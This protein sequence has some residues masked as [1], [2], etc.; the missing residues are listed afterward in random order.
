MKRQGSA[1][2]IG[3]LK[4][5]K[6]NV[7]TESGTLDNTPY[8]F[9]SR[10]EGAVETNPEE[11]IGAAHAGC[12]SMAFAAQLEKEGFK[13]DSIDTT[14]VVTLEKNDDGYAITAIHLNVTAHVPKID[15]DK[16]NSIANAA[17]EGCPVSKLM[18]A[19]ITMDAKLS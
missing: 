5:G 7:S 9:K 3:G 18:K 13:A 15:V 1:K 19:T 8:S 6:G 11:L 12:F 17:K 16:F 4:D 10:F 14:A 2:W